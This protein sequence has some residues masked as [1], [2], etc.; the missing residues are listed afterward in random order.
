MLCIPPHERQPLPL[1]PLSDEKS[2]PKK[3]RKFPENGANVAKKG[4][5][6]SPFSSSISGTL[7]F[8]CEG[9]ILHSLKYV[10]LVL[11]LLCQKARE[12]NSGWV[13]LAS[14][15]RNTGRFSGRSF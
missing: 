13:S 6:T 10:I 1:S 7:T 8:K 2:S 14:E 3:A 4:P 12:G 11:K 5:Y 15:Q 9:S